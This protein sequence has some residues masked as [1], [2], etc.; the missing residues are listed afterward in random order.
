MLIT[1]SNFMNNV[2]R[3]KNSFPHLGKKVKRAS[4]MIAFNKHDAH[5]HTLSAPDQ[6]TSSGAQVIGSFPNYENRVS[7]QTEGPS[8]EQQHCSCDFPNLQS[9]RV[10]LMCTS[11]S[12]CDRCRHTWRFQDNRAPGRGAATE[13]MLA[14]QPQSP[15]MS[16]WYIWVNP[17]WLAEKLTPGKHLYPCLGCHL[18]WQFWQWLSKW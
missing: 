3:K 8:W 14:W 18:Q 13:T 12:S 15:V 9:P 7:F 6:L 4:Q 5:M 2:V 1:E 10:T 16:L 11:H 17:A